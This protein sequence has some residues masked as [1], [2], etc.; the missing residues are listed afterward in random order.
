MNDERLINRC[1]LLWVLGVLLA[2]TAAH[3]IADEHERELVLVMDNGDMVSAGIWPDERKCRLV[4]AVYAIGW[5]PVEQA[6]C[7]ETLPEMS[8]I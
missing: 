4:G 3:C 5:E 8:G 6:E 1:I 7:I 2:V